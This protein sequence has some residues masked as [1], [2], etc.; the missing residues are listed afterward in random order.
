M[1]DTADKL[2]ENA[3]ELVINEQACSVTMLQRRFALGYSAAARLVD[4]LEREG[5]VGPPQHM[6]LSGAVLVPRQTTQDGGQR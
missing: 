3:K 6:Q 1:T 5:I 2:Y 4:R